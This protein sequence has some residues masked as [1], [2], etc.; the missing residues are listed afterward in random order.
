MTYNSDSEIW[1]NASASAHS[2]TIIDKSQN[3]IDR[4]KVSL[5]NEKFYSGRGKPSDDTHTN[6]QSDRQ[7]RLYDSVIFEGKP[8]G[9]KSQET[10]VVQ[11]QVIAH[12]SGPPGE[13][14]S[15]SHHNFSGKPKGDII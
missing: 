4:N 1:Q 10:V 6:S 14:S 13:E 3:V 8:S 5:S 12:T 15:A 2:N 7:G 11:T 9:E